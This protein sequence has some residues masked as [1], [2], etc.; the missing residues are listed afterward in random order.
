MLD[1]YIVCIGFIPEL[2]VGYI[3][4]TAIPGVAGVLNLG[5]SCVSLLYSPFGVCGIDGEGVDFLKEN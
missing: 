2:I 4:G 5:V 3:F 1:V